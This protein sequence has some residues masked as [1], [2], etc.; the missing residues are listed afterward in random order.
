M[1]ETTK[2]SVEKALNKIRE[3]D[4]RKDKADRIDDEIAA[5]DEETKRLRAQRLRLEGHQRRS[6]KRD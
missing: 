6:S 4:A 2:L 5:L 3:S 1:A